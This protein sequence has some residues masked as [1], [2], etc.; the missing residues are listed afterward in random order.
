MSGI[1]RW[2]LD[3]WK[4]C[5]PLLVEYHCL[6]VRLVKGRRTFVQKIRLQCVSFVSF[7][8]GCRN[9]CSDLIDGR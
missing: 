3:F 8:F 9:N 1:L 7:I 5:K 2:F 6:V 4:V